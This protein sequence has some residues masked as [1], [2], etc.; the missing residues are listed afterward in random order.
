MTTQAP[1]AREIHALTS[2]LSESR[3]EIESTHEVCA[4]PGC[5]YVC[6]GLIERHCCRVCAG[7]PGAHGPRCQKRHLRC[8][9]LA[10]SFLCTGVSVAHCC[11]LCARG[12][13][14]GPLCKRLVGAG[15]G[16]AVDDESSGDEEALAGIPQAAGDEEDAADAADADWVTPRLVAAA[17]AADPDGEQEAADE[18]EVEGEVEG[19]GEALDAEA[20]DDEQLA[21]LLD[22]EIEAK[23]ALIEA[24]DAQLAELMARLEQLEGEVPATTTVMV[25]VP[26]GVYENQEFVIEYEGQQ[27]TV[28]CP[29]GC[30]PGVDLHLEVPASTAGAGALAAGVDAASHVD[31]SSHGAPARHR[32]RCDA[33]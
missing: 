11:R 29:A 33:S 10:C 16:D 24:Q 9:N 32:R 22:E 2:L 31:A 19:E 28:C 5:N 30:G 12:E 1:Y 4:S 17:A 27:L 15:I 6:T 18:V 3:L 21:A 23:E 13:G 25:T 26:D 20:L 8:A 14:H 7:A